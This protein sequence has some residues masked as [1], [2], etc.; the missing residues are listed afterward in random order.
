MKRIENYNQ[1][2]VRINR[3]FS[4]S[5]GCWTDCAGRDL[6]EIR[7]G[8]QEI[9]ESLTINFECQSMCVDNVTFPEYLSV[10]EFHRNVN[11]SAEWSWL[12][13]LGLKTKKTFNDHFWGVMIHNFFVVQRYKVGMRV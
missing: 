4:F 11:H 13:L 12:H 5:D 1:S 2:N 6:R 10:L 9:R 7:P 8:N 3:P